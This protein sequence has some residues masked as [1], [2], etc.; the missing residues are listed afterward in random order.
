[1]VT[2]PIHSNAKFN[3][4]SIQHAKNVAKSLKSLLDS[5]GYTIKLSKA[6]AVVAKL[7]GHDDWH[8]LEQSV[9]PQLRLGPLDSELNAEELRLRHDRMRSVLCDNGISQGLAAIVL[10]KVGPTGGQR[11]D[12]ALVWVK[13]SEGL[14]ETTSHKD[15]NYRIYPGKYH[16]PGALGFSV[17]DG[18]EKLR[19]D[20]FT[21]MHLYQ[22]KPIY[23][24]GPS[25]DTAE[26]VAGEIDASWQDHRLEQHELKRLNREPCDVRGV[27]AGMR[28][29]DVVKGCSVA[30]GLFLLETEDGKEYWRVTAPWLRLLP[31]AF[32]PPEID[33]ETC[34][35]YL[36]YDIGALFPL[37]FPNV[38]TTAE[39]AR[40][41]HS[42]KEFYPDAYQYLTLGDQATEIQVRRAGRGFSTEKITYMHVADLPIDRDGSRVMLARIYSTFGGPIREGDDMLQRSEELHMFKKPAKSE[43]EPMFDHDDFEYIGPYGMTVDEYMDATKSVTVPKL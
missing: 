13:N 25:A 3:L 40:A 35:D 19:G 31:P 26:A 24:G 33:D 6:Q 17:S 38:F 30:E 32:Q 29:R 14:L 23:F 34:D 1:M 42:L 41:A 27:T 11:P 2:H 37:C 22:G 8:A 15:F 5:V 36:T 9:S 18:P 16:N 39:V 12:E 7:Y 20:G 28:D 43:F 10:E 21:A 4:H